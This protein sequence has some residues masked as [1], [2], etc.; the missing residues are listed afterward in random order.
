VILGVTFIFFEL[1]W[2]TF[3]A[4]TAARA[5]QWL[6]KPRRAVLFNRI[7]GVVFLLAATLLATS[8]RNPA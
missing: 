7:T 6:Q 4:F 2:L 8:K 5:S 3:Y 1:F